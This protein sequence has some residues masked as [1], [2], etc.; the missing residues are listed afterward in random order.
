MRFIVLKRDRRPPAISRLAVAASVAGA[1]TVLAP[2]AARAGTLRESVGYMYVGNTL[3]PVTTDWSHTFNFQGFNA[4]ASADG[5]TGATLTGVAFKYTNNISGTVKLYN[6]GASG[7]VGGAGITNT[8]Y[9]GTSST[10]TIIAHGS[11]NTSSSLSIGAGVTITKSVSGTDSSSMTVS[12]S[13]LSAYL[14][15]YSQLFSDAGGQSSGFTGGNVNVTP[16]DQGSL[17]VDVTYTYMP[18]A[19]PPPKNLPEPGS[20]ALLGTGLLGLGL[21]ATRRRRRF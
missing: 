17:L 7:A 5:I 20:L 4:L 9:A 3:N 13:A 19:E 18:K 21:V 14:A 8:I 2:V 16:T 15:G 11:A 12:A 6:K 10:G 1:L